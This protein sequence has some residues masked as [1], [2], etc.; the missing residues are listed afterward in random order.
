TR[1]PVPASAPTAVRRSERADGAADDLTRTCERGLA[2]IDLLTIP[3]PGVDGEDVRV[4]AAGIPWFLTLFGRDSL[5]TAYFLLPY[6][7]ATAAAVLSALA[8][9]QGRRHDPFSGEQP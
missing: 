9:T 7:P 5:L 3:V 4:P 8:A 6:R 1:P 2:D